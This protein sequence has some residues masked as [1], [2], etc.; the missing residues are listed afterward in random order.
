MRRWVPA[1]AAALVLASGT[2]APAWAQDRTLRSRDVERPVAESEAARRAVLEEALRSTG[3]PAVLAGAVDP[4]HYRMGPSDVL[5]LSLWGGV[6]RSV[7]LEVGPE[8][9]IMVPGSGS[10]KID[11]LT[12]R[13]ARNE[14]LSRLRGEFRGVNMD[15]RL[16][17]PRKFR[18]YLT[19]QVRVPGP[20]DATGISRVGDVLA[21]S[22]LNPGASR[23]SIEVIHR[24]G[25]REIA[26]LDLFLHTADGSLNPWLRDGDVMHV[27]VATEFVSIQGAVARAAIYEL[28]PHDSLSTLVRI[29]GGV[30]PSADST[31]MLFIRWNDAARS[32]SM[33]IKLTD[34]E[35][36]KFNPRLQNGDRLYIYFVPQYQ[37]LDEATIL[38]QVTRPGIYPIREGRDRISD[39]VKAAGGFLP[40]AD[41]GAITV[42][43]V[44][45]QNAEKDAELQ[46]L[47][48]LSRRELTDTEYEVLRTKLAGL[49]EEYRLDWNRVLSEG[50]PLDILLFNGDVVQVDRLI[51]S[52]RIDGEVRRPGI[53]MYRPGLGVE[54]YIRT[55]GGYSKRAW[56]SKVRVTRSVTGQT[57]LARDLA[58]LDPGDFVWVPEKPDVTAWDQFRVLLTSVAEIATVIIAIR[59]LR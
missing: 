58:K 57:L 34:V 19:G 52:I 25:T 10:I 36:G 3:E 59:S 44:S 30:V 21:S 42:R 14:I 55:A 41:L 48:R 7:I 54:D 39:V 11:G 40:G 53:L 20:M 45:R 2:I 16:A 38:G 13:Q 29:G 17:R 28:G 9:T 24:D 32:D 46:R 12:L 51:S 47:L 15:V 33:W 26:D 1:A 18:V 5:L 22:I 8:G 50:P 43:R 56:R 27:P 37:L 6:S 23:R 31:R 35:S 4:D 49:R